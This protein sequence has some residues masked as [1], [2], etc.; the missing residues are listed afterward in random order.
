MQCCLMSS[1][2]WKQKLWDL[3]SLD[4][5][6]GSAGQICFKASQP[7]NHFVNS[8]ICF[9]PQVLQ[10]DLISPGYLRKIFTGIKQNYGIKT[11][12]LTHNDEETKK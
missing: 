2:N 4:G 6:V 5:N 10:L 3:L 7:I 12:I 1:N 9:K 11:L 8:V